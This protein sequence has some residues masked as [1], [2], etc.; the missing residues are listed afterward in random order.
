M[1]N[2]TDLL[3]GALDIIKLEDRWAQVLISHTFLVKYLDSKEIE[4]V[5]KDEY[6]LIEEY[7]LPIKTLQKLGVEFKEKEIKN[8]RYGIEQEYFPG[9][10]TEVNVF[11]KY[12]KVG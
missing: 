5:N 11:G 10:K 8:I 6:I 7:N 9:L 2:I 1:K 3:P 4:R 12:K